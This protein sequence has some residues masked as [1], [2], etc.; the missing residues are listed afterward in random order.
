MEDLFLSQGLAVL[1]CVLACLGPPYAGHPTYFLPG[2]RERRRRRVVGLKLTGSC[3][4][5]FRRSYAGRVLVWSKVRVIWPVQL[6][7]A[8]WAHLV[9]GWT[10]PGRA[11]QFLPSGTFLGTVPGPTT[12]YRPAQH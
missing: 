7:F 5:V 12:V 1:L 11:G 10:P 9:L 3:G 6:K 2:L 4:V 8:L